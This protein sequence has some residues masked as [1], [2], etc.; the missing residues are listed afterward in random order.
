MINVIN[1]ST[2]LINSH[3]TTILAISL[4]VKPINLVEINLDKKF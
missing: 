3:H 1:H 4:S 2:A